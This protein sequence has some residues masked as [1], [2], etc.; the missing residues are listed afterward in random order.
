MIRAN[1]LV[2]HI[3]TGEEWVV[4][5]VDYQTDRL[6]PCGYPFPT[7]ARISDCELLESRE[8]KQ[9]M[10]MKM[11]LEREGLPGMIEEV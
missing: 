8:E 2:K 10:Q 1:D 6:V 9:S 7:M 3:P 4:A 11:L 5:G